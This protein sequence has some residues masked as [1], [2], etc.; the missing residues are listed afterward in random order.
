[1]LPKHPFGSGRNNVAEF[2]GKYG[3]DKKPPML[4][5]SSTIKHREERENAHIQ[6]SDPGRGAGYPV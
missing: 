6:Q 4:Y 5:Y 2:P 3:L 1:V